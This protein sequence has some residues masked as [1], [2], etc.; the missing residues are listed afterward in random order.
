MQNSDVDSNTAGASALTTGVGG[1][2]FLQD[3]CTGGTCTSVAT[4]IMNSLVTNN[5]AH[6]V[7]TPPRLLPCKI[8]ACPHPHRMFRLVEGCSMT[9][10]TPAACSR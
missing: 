7:S 5:Y 8:Q 2:I 3:Y 4:T 1:G 9:D 6:L 10:Q